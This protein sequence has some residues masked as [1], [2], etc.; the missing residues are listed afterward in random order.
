MTQYIS[1]FFSSTDEDQANYYKFKYSELIN[2]KEGAIDNILKNIASNIC[3]QFLQDIEFVSYS[4]PKYYVGILNEITIHAKIKN[5]PVEI[6]INNEILAFDNCIYDSKSNKFPYGYGNNLPTRT[7]L[8]MED[9]C[10]PEN[11]DN[12]KLYMES[13]YKNQYSRLK[14]LDNAIKDKHMHIILTIVHRLIREY[15]PMFNGTHMN[16]Y[17]NYFITGIS[18]DATTEKTNIT[19]NISINKYAIEFRFY[20][21]K[22]YIDEKNSTDEQ[23]QFIE[24]IKKVQIPDLKGYMTTMYEE[25]CNN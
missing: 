8:V 3:H 9:S 14:N 7:K 2:Q 6:D 23:K 1:K 12:I 18:F 21:N 11:F 20:C 25:L 16:N 17:S 4:K 24:S 13:E 22:K 19:T 5:I 15:Y 10:N